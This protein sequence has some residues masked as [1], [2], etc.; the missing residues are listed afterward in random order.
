[1]KFRFSIAVISATLATAISAGCSGLKVQRV[2]PGQSIRRHLEAQQNPAPGA[3]S[4]TGAEMP[5]PS[6]VPPGTPNPAF[7]GQPAPGGFVPPEQLPPLPVVGLPERSDALEKA[8][9]AYQRG[10]TLAKGGQDS[11]AI[12]AFEEATLIDPSFA[13]AWTQLTI[14]Y[15]RTGQP[16]KARDAFRRAKSLNTRPEKLTTPTVPNPSV[17]PSPQLAPPLPKAESI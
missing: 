15:E 17:L 16:A 6:D 5:Q 3:Q 1:M 11:D 13:D 10:I 14:L 12:T 7:P 4:L 2:P 8:M 9:D